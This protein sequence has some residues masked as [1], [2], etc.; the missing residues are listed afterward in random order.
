MQEQT[1]ETT[2]TQQ[3]APA[4][5]ETREMLLNIGPAHPAMHGII[6][7]VAKLDGEQIEEAEVEIGYLHRG[8]EKMA[9]VVDYNG[10]IPY[11]D[12]LS[13]CAA[14]IRNTKTSA[15][16][17]TRPPLPSAAFSWYDIAFQAMDVS[18]GSTSAATS[19]RAAR[20]CDEL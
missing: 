2:R 15:I 5:L 20:V 16:T 17:N 8:F 19:S 4:D 12:R 14:R 10:V 6:G 18:G 9:E 3:G 7:I 1:T 13:Y 11:T